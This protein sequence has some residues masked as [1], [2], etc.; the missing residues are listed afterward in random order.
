MPFV[1][2]NNCY[3]AE[4]PPITNVSESY[5]EYSSISAMTGLNYWDCHANGYKVKLRV[6]DN[7]PMNSLHGKP[8]PI[9]E[10]A[11]FVK[12]TFDWVRDFF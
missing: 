2:I 11:M 10:A 4:T 8:K 5:R 3:G 9:R 6:D 7:L 12:I 1:V